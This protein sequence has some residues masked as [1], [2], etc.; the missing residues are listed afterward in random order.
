VSPATLV[1]A[2]GVIQAVN[3]TATASDGVVIDLGNVTLLPGFIDMHVHTLVRDA[4][5]YRADILAETGADAVMRSTVGARKMLM[6]GFTTIRD[7]AQLHLTPDLLVVAM[8]R[9]ADAGWID[10]PRIVAAGHAISITGGHIDPEMHAGV[11]TSLFRLGPELGIA[12]GEAASRGLSP[13][14]H[15]PTRGRRTRER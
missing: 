2:G 5:S 4:T 13:R 8:A 12:D 9:A 15:N 3:P 11:S 1:V 14:L 7:M 6:A 10:A